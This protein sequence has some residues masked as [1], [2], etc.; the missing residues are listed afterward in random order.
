[1][2]TSQMEKWRLLLSTIKSATTCVLQDFSFNQFNPVLTTFW[3]PHV[4]KGF[5][6]AK[7]LSKVLLKNIYEVVPSPST[8]V[9]SGLTAPVELVDASG[10]TMLTVFWEWIY[11]KVVIGY[12]SNGLHES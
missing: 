8:K 1:M 2:K 7:K 12:F 4:K 6:R 5:F 10:E 11:K 3:G 9:G